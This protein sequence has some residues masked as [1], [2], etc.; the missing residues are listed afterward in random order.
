[1]L[2][3]GH[4]KRMYEKLA[5]GELLQE[6]ERLEMLLFNAYPRKNTNPIAH[7][8]LNAFGS[9]RGVLEADVKELVAIEGVGESV[10]LYLKCVAACAKPA[11][12]SDGAEVT[13]KNYG[14]FKE[15]TV[16]RLR[17]K[18]EEVLELYM[19]DRSGTVKYIFSRRSGNSHKV[20]VERDEITSAIAAAKPYGILIAHNHLTGDS[21]PSE[22]D[23]KFTAE[24]CTLCNLSGI[25]LYDHC[26]YAADNNVYSYFTAG[27]LDEIKSKFNLN[28][29]INSRK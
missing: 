28:S 18:T 13:L 20:S 1:M 8:L 16:R 9:L 7:A 24:M 22:Q 25:M 19:L 27:K 6:H 12:S 23:D 5:A 4:R 3:E 11:Y 17:A 10:A 29:L 2:H 21:L 15:F 26:I 14:D